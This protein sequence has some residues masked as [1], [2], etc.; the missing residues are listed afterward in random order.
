M[1]SIGSLGRGSLIV[2]GG[3]RGGGLVGR[4]A[5]ATRSEEACG[6]GGCIGE[7]LKEDEG[8]GL[9]VYMYDKRV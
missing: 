3:R 5:P 6:T 7:V 4:T 9:Y 8:N 2:I 1:G